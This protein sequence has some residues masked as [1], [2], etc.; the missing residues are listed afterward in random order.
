M[1]AVKDGGVSFLL[2][3]RT[4]D[5]GDFWQPLT[6][7]LEDGEKLKSCILR[8]LKEETGIDERDVI[9]ITEEIWRFNWL[10]WK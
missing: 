5:D 1:Y 9:A 2:L 10:L 7:T 3:H 6:G 8:E 4:P